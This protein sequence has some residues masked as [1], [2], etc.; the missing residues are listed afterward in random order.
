MDSLVFDE[1]VFNKFH[2]ESES[3]VKSVK[4]M[5]IQVE[6][7]VRV[8]S[9]ECRPILTQIT[10]IKTKAK[11]LAELQNNVTER[12]RKHSVEKKVLVDI[13]L[14]KQEIVVLQNDLS[15]VTLGKNIT[16]ATCM[17]ERLGRITSREKNLREHLVDV[18]ARFD[19]CV[20]AGLKDIISDMKEQ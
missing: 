5:E 19:D 12:S 20:D 7:H 16:E 3:C 4:K 9:K 11:Q 2:I 6:E 13:D 17:K 10:S 8:S 1:E 18:Q 14:I 15:G